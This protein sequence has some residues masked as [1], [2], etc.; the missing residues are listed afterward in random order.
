MEATHD[1]AL[2]GPLVSVILPVYNRAGWVARAIDSVL[3]Q[4]YRH[5]EVLVIDDGSTDD[6]LRVLEGFGSRIEVLRQPHAGA[7]AA[8][9]L[10]LARASGEFVAFIDSDDVWYAERLS[11]QLPLFD[12]EAVG[13]VFGNAALVDYRRTPPRRLKRT[14]FDG[15]R[16]SRGRVLEDFARGCFVPFSSVLARRRCFTEK[17]GFTLGRVAADYL[18][19]LEISVRYEFAYLP[20]PV[21]EYAI[22]PGGISHNL[23]ETLEDRVEA[24]REML[25][26]N[27]DAEIGRVLRRILFNLRL[28]LAV[29]RLRQRLKGRP[30]T[31]AAV[32]PTS[33]VVPDVTRGECLSWTLKFACDQLRT[34][35][36]W[37]ILKSATALYDWRARSRSKVETISRP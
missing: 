36:R 1:G 28:S 17:G 37:W 35:G 11:R 4:T 6:T 22:H 2:T 30:A 20:E 31:A 33:S 13:V 18:K 12:R 3:A 15:V 34:R 9:N 14:F 25:A 7:E 8:R 16:P 10:G 32:V 29:A 21:F 23:L 19:W 24:F 26:R 27:S 5:L